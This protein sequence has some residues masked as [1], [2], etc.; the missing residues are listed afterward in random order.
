[1][2][3]KSTGYIKLYKF[4]KYIFWLL[5]VSLHFIYVVREIFMLATVVAHYY[6]HFGPTNT[7]R[8]VGPENFTKHIMRLNNGNWNYIYI[9]YIII[10]LGVEFSTVMTHDV[11]ADRRIA[12][13]AMRRVERIF[14][15]MT[16]T[17]YSVSKER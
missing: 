14:H 2:C 8:S 9:C 1:L 17:L 15:N 11:D 13:R 7:I 16:W 10:V 5:L 3:C 6:D 12:W 4:I